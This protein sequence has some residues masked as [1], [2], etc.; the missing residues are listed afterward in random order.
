MRWEFSYVH[1][2]AHAWPRGALCRAAPRRARPRMA[3]Y[4]VPW[5]T[6]M[7]NHHQNQNTAW[8]RGV[9]GKT[10]VTAD[11]GE[12]RPRDHQQGGRHET[13]IQ[14]WFNNGP[15]SATLSHH[16]IST[17]DCLEK[18]EGTGDGGG[19]PCQ[20]GQTVPANQSGDLSGTEILF[21]LGFLPPPPLVSP[22]PLPSSV[23]T[24]LLHTHC[25]HC[26]PG[27][28]SLPTGRGGSLLTERDTTDKPQ[29]LCISKSQLYQG[30]YDT[31]YWVPNMDWRPTLHCRECNSLVI[32]R[33][34]E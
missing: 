22:L 1:Y 25:F 7:K 23:T 19:A 12:S 32:S 14:C 6:C 3:L 13:L 31:E 11:V 24:P 28:G 34:V 9:G 26:Q 30:G 33:N 2:L 10:A 29:T 8:R 17:G 16:Y 27:R 18:G 20:Q 15:A 4:E 21:V 5:P